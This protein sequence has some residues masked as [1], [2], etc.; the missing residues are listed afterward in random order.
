MQNTTKHILITTGLLL[1][2]DLSAAPTEDAESDSKIEEIVVTARKREESI[3][4]VPVAL[5]IFSN[6]TLEKNRIRDVDNLFARAPGLYVSQN[7]TF[8][9]TKSETYITMR[10]IGATTPLEPAVAV[11]LDGVYQ[12]KL[13]FDIDF[14]ELERLEILRGPQGTLF[15]RNT[16]GGALNLVS[17]KP[18]SEFEGKIQGTVDEHNTFGVK[19]YL[20]GP[21]SEKNQLYASFAG[22]Y[23]TTDGYFKNRTSNNQQDNGN[24]KAARGTLLWFPT[25]IFEISLV[26]YISDRDSGQVGAGV[27]TGME[28]HVVFDN[29]T[30][31]IVDKTVGGNLTIDLSLPHFDLTSI[32]GVAKIKT[33]TFFDLDGGSSGKGNNQIQRFEQTLTSEELRISSNN[34]ESRLNLLAGLYFFTSTYDQHRTFNLLDPASA[35]LGAGVFAF[36]FSPDNDVNE[37][38]DFKRDGWAVFGQ[39]TLQ[40]TKKLELTIGAR[41]SSETV[42][43]RQHG[44]IEIV[45]GAVV[46]AYDT[47]AKETFRGFSPSASISYR[48]NDEASI[49]GTIARGFKAGGF[50]KYPFFQDGTGV[51]FKSEK[52]LNHEVG[53]KGNWLASRGLA[54]NLALFYIKVDD[55]QLGTQVNGPAN[56]PVELVDNV[57]SS[58]STGFEVDLVIQPTDRLRLTSAVSYII[59]KFEDYTFEGRDGMGATFTVVRD[60][61]RV[62]Y[63]P[64]WL[65]N[66]AAEYTHPIFTSMD[67]TWALS[68]SYIGSNTVGNGNGQFDPKIPIKAYDVIDFRVS[69]ENDSWNATFFVDNVLDDFNVVRTWKSPFHDQSLFSFDT[70]APPRTIGVTL[71][72]KW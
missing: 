25:D 10:G 23:E 8:G 58:S 12:P 33:E 65:V 56:I 38:A 60:G 48:L 2:F 32:T 5:S 18:G 9:P 42:D 1:T 29:D 63:V 34:T 47:T 43:S 66:V 46:S 64:K 59:A 62:P 6:E 41:Y 70:V 11:F 21:I 57:G 52:S 28:D 4:D 40:I 37:F 61:E 24:N 3:L 53:L 14:L 13:G 72:Y 20:S 51:P 54:M 31:D 26:G 50:P 44:R 45:G 69:V 27:P 35:A 15:G 71:T 39:G 55:Q 22:S 17:K 49:Y 30:R 19:V 7:Q 16:Q 67:A 36:V 68:Y